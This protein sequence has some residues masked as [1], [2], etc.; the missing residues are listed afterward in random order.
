MHSPLLVS[1]GVSCQSWCQ[2]CIAVAPSLG[3]RF[4]LTEQNIS[5]HREEKG[6]RNSVILQFFVLSQVH[7]PEDKTIKG[8]APPLPIKDSVSITNGCVTQNCEETWVGTYILIELQDMPSVS[9]NTSVW[10]PSLRRCYYWQWC[11]LQWT[12]KTQRRA[13]FALFVCSTVPAGLS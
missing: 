11:L 5:L 9:L 10:L 12:R 13:W 8:L 4:D 1:D 3:E 2:R 7:T 6:M